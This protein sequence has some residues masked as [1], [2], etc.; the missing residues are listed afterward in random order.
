MKQTACLTLGIAIG[1]AIGGVLGSRCAQSGRI[2]AEGDTVSR[3]VFVDTIVCYKPVP[4]D[5]VVIRYEVATLPRV[6]EDGLATGLAADTL[7]TAEGDSAK[8]VIPIV[9]AV[10]ED[11]A[12]TAYVSGYRARLDSIF[13][14]PRREVVTIKKPPKRWSVGVQAGYGCTPKG[15]QPYV[16]IGISCRILEF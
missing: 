7:T 11:S 14:Y 12:Y 1:L 9:Q 8:V 3:E 10:Y 5:S 4:K 6:K 2:P 16:G 13:V 15:F